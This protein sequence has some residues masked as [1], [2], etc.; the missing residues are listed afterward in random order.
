M[1]VSDFDVVVWPASDERGA[2]QREMLEVDSMDAAL[3]S[4]TLERVPSAYPR[5][6]CAA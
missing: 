4:M 1:D 5:G 3:A 6:F 2:W